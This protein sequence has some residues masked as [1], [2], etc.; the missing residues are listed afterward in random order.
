MASPID[1][2]S[3]LQITP[4]LAALHLQLSFALVPQALQL[5]PHAGCSHHPSSP[6]SSFSHSFS[7]PVGLGAG[8]PCWAGPG[9]QERGR[10]DITWENMHVHSSED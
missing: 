2:P 7:S 6:P 9:Q 1:F 5:F 10:K 3:E 4:R 8:G